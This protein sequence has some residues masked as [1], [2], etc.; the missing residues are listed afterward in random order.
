MPAPTANFMEPAARPVKTP[1]PGLAAHYRNGVSLIIPP[2]VGF[3]VAKYSCK[4][5]AFINL[6]LARDEPI[7]LEGFLHHSGARKR[8]R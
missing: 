1:P 6:T 3:L 8:D 5:N 4:S 2:Y 7:F